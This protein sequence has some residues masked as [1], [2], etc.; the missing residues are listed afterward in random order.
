MCRDWASSNRDLVRET[1]K[2][3]RENN[4]HLN[5]AKAGRYRS[6]K[7][8]A[9][10]PWLDEE[11]NW[12]IDEIYQLSCLRTEMTGVGHHVDHI[13]PLQGEAVKGLHV[14]WNLQV[15]TATDNLKKRNS[16]GG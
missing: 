2:K 10:P 14:P 15:I 1:N 4:P 9:T 12:M 5:A 7:L 11:L 16:L 3:W 8:K 6:S 13:V